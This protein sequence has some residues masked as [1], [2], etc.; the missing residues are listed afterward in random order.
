MEEKENKM[1][2]KMTVFCTE[3]AAL[4]RFS[5]ILAFESVSRRNL[6]HFLNGNNAN[7]PL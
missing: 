2:V 7:V 3:Y 5:E 4:R 1:E 6:V